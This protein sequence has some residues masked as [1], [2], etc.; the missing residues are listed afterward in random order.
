MPR[1]RAVIV[2]SCDPCARATSKSRPFAHF[3]N[4]PS[5]CV[6]C[7]AFCTRERPPWRPMTSAVRPWSSSSCSVCAYSRAV[8]STSSP[9]PRMISISGRKTSTCALAVMSIHTLIPPQR[10]QSRRLRS[11]PAPSS[12]RR[13]C[14]EHFHTSRPNARRLLLDVALVPERE[15]EKAPQLPAPVLRA[16][17]V[18]VDVPVDDAR[19]EEALR[20][21]RLRREGRAR[22]RLEL[23]SQPG[24][25]RDREAALSPVHDL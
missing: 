21:Q 25:G 3:F 23:S 5:R 1:R 2:S 14:R 17:D 6:I 4:A 13:S 9:R 7:L 15:R 11:L 20:A 12:P 10:R 22:E 16:G 19:L 18:L 8:I 24:G